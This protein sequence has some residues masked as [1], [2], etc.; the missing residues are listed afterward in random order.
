MPVSKRTMIAQEEWRKVPSEEGLEASNCGRV[1]RNGVLLTAEKQINI[2][3]VTSRIGRAVLEAFVGPCPDGMECCHY[4]DDATN[5]RLSN[6]RWDT[7]SANMSDRCRNSGHWGAKGEAQW[8]AKFTSARVVLARLL[9][10]A[11]PNTFTCGTLADIFGMKYHTVD[12]VLRRKNW[13]HLP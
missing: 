7:A 9:H 11:F 1:R 10:T 8:L 6:L 12:K 2:N 4:D 3:G 5:N 13:K